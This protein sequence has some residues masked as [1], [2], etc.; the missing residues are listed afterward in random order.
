[1]PG[2]RTQWPP[3]WS[4]MIKRGKVGARLAWTGM[5]VAEIAAGWVLTP[6]EPLQ[7]EL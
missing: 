4:E 2:G 7:R 5:Q 3:E 1:M 6:D